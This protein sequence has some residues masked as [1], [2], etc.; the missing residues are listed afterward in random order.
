MAGAFNKQ[1]KLSTPDEIRAAKDAAYKRVE[2]SDVVYTPQALARLKTEAEDYLGKKAYDPGLQP[3]VA[4]SLRDIQNKAEGGDNITLQGLDVIRQ[5]ASDAFDPMNKKSGKLGAS[6]IEQIDN[7]VAAPKPGDVLMGDAGAAAAAITEARKLNTQISK[8]DRITEALTKGERR[9]ERTGSGGNADN[10]TR[11]NISAI[12]DNPK[13]ARGFTADERAAM[14]QIVRGTPS[15]NALRLVGK[16][17]PSG[18]GLMAALGVGATAANPALAAI[19]VAG[20]AAKTLADRATN[21]NVD[22]LIRILRAGGQRSAA[23]APDNAVQRL[24]ET[25]RDA[26]IRTLMMGGLA[27]APRAETKP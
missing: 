24:A 13:K 20:M 25:K 3:R 26:L 1:P 2:Q 22:E 5:K 18:N 23:F 8:I 19:P 17:S 4:P 14:E 12:L 6:I 11:Q 21:K 27:V 16:L 7:L 9:T 15:Q 10:V